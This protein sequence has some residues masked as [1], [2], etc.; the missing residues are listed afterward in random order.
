MGNL[1]R[2]R[3]D[4]LY[5]DVKDGVPV[6]PEQAIGRDLSR[7]LLLFSIE[8]LAIDW[9]DIQ[10]IHS[11]FPTKR[12]LF[13]KS[14]LAQALP[15]EPARMDKEQSSMSQPDITWLSASGHAAAICAGINKDKRSRGIYNEKTLCI[16]IRACVVSVKR[17][18]TTNFTHIDMRKL[19]APLRRRWN[20]ANPPFIIRWNVQK[21][22]SMQD[23]KPWRVRLSGRMLSLQPGGEEF[24]PSFP[25]GLW[26]LVRG[27]NERKAS[28]MGKLLQQRHFVFGVRFERN[29]LRLGYLSRWA[30]KGK[31]VLSFRFADL[32]GG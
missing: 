1:K 20:K 7:D 28:E 25:S 2:L 27:Q 15:P 30:S 16:G 17:H 31:R 22:L 9:L 19:R 4:A 3:E 6:F 23:R 5:W 10:S 13:L 32:F 18:R 8:I 24:S 12:T 14:F 26:P 21:A 11:G 29:L